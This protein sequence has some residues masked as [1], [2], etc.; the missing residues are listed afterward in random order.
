MLIT[1]DNYLSKIRPFYDLDIIKVLMGSRRSGKSK[2]L[3]LIREELLERSVPKENILFMNF[4]NLEY[5]DIDDYKKLN[6]YVLSK[7]SEGKNYLFFD[8]IHHVDHFE[9]AINS[10]RAT[11]DCSIFITGSNSKLLSTEISSLLTGRIIEFTV[12]PFTYEECVRYREINNIPIPNNSFNDYLMLGGYPFRFNLLEEQ[13][14]K[15]Y[16]NELY[17]S[18]CQKDIFTRDREIEK[19]KFNKV[20]EYVLV[21]A[22]NDFNPDVIY[23]YLKTNNKG[24]EYITNRAIYKYLERMTNAFLVKPIYRYNIAGKAALKSN[25]KYYAIDNGFRYIKAN[26]N[27]FDRGRF[28]ENVICVELLS[29]GYEVFVGKTYKGEVDFVAMRN[30]KKCFIQ[31]AYIMESNETIEREFGAFSPISDA[32]PKY[33]LSLD[34]IDMSRNGIIHLNI[35]DFLMHKVDLYLS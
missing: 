19:E 2:I 5:D 18:I 16:L 8:E 34:Q 35:V 9:K 28:L 12:Y 25:P 32:S 31:V 1:R 6:S 3:E 27:N 23:N 10:F 11:L 26:L 30:G 24:K 29:R 4:E 13:A 21:N 22:G 20:C 14:V 7:I 17:N 15:S 33:V